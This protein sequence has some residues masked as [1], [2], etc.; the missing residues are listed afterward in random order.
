MKLLDQQIA[1]MEAKMATYKAQMSAGEEEAPK[2][3]SVTK[4]QAMLSKAHNDERIVLFDDVEKLKKQREDILPMPL[5]LSASSRL[6]RLEKLN[7]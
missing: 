5:I 3:P 7:W 1:E 6:R 4:L 2:N